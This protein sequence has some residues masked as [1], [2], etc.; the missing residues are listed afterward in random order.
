VIDA[1]SPTFVENGDL[2]R[3]KT[4][5]VIEDGPTLTHGEMSYGAGVVAAQRLGAAALVDPRPYAVRSIADT[6]RKYPNTGTLLPAMGYGDAQCVDL[7]ETIRATPC[8]V[9][10]V[11]TPIDIT[12]VITIRQP[13][14]R[15]SYEL[16]ELGTPTV[17]QVLAEKFGPK[18]ALPGAKAGKFSTK[19]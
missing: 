11:A 6:F 19:G 3:G 10:V 12:R 18:A 7:E 15:V 2:L 5:L 13:T 1:A 9:V 14:V 17:A 4:V 16:Q 8:D